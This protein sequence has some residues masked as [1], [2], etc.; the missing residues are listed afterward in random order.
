MLLRAACSTCIAYTSWCI[1][2]HPAHTRPVCT[3]KFNYALHHP[4]LEPVCV[5]QGDAPVVWRGPIVNSAID[6][7]LMGTAWGP[8]DMLLVDMPPGESGCF[9]LD[10]KVTRSRSPPCWMACTTQC[11]RTIALCS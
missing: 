1:Q 4:W 5:M 8:L 7:F 9:G 10:E 6:R 3:I 2:R 11:G